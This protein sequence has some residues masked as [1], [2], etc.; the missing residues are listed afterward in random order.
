[1]VEKRRIVNNHL[2][3]FF[4]NSPKEIPIADVEFLFRN[5]PQV[6]MDTLA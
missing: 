5:I 6:K 1:M 4:Q 2:S 3:G